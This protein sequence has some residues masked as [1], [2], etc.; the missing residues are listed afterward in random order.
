MATRNLEEAKKAYELGDIE[1]SK[2]AHDSKVAG[3]TEQ[4]KKGGEFLKSFVFGGMDGIITTFSIVSGTIG[5][6]LGSAIVVIL[7]L[8]NV[9]AD[10]LSMA[11]G[12]YLST[13]SEQEFQRAERKRETWEVENNPEGEILE[14]EQ[15]YSAKGMDK[16][17]AKLMAQTLSKNK[18]AWIDIMMVEELGIIEDNES[19][20][21]NALVTFFSFVIC[22][23]F[24]LIPFFIGHAQ[25]AD[26]LVVFYWAI[27]VT[28]LSLFA[29]GASKTKITDVKW[30]KSGLETLFV[31]SIAAGCA[32]LIG[33]LLEP[34][35]EED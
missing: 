30:W 10:A 35:A 21:K 7:G 11:F 8:S 12:D 16:E 9:F 25:E 14:M 17:D 20:A 26:A 18:K 32:F 3:S 33:Y 13:K 24:P 1:A 5:S 27:A 22:G 31:G 4:H 28:A 19:P 23:I 34:L 15:L 6:D 29:L 2:A